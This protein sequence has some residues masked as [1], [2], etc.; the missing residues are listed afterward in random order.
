MRDILIIYASNHGATAQIASRI[1]ETLKDD[2]ARTDLRD[3]GSATSIALSDY[4]AVV[5]GGSIHAGHHQRALVDWAKQHATQ[6]NELP[7]VFFSVSLSAAEESDEARATARKYVGDFLD[8][9]GWTPRARTSFAGALQYREYD[10]MTRL[11]IRLIARHQG[12]PTD[13]SRD[14]VFTDWD[15]VERFAHDCARMTPGFAPATA[16]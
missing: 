11:L 12:Q 13:T 4:D 10:F 15:A 8:E 1:A 6:L 5:V 9:T 14:F 7:A 2:G 3:V 16:P